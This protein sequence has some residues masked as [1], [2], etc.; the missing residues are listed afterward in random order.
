MQETLHKNLDSSNTIDNKEFWS[1]IKSGEIISVKKTKNQIHGNIVKAHTQN[2]Y[3]E[4]VVILL[5]LVETVILANPIEKLIEKR[6]R[7]VSII[8]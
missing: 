4:T 5:I 1:T 3:F 6:K 7:Q 8:W 2:T